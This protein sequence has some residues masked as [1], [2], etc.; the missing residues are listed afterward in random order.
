MKKGFLT[1]FL[2]MGLIALSA[3]SGFACDY[4]LL[5]QGISPLDTIK[6]AGVRVNQRYT[7]MD[8]VYRGTEELDNPG[9]K[10][11]YWTTEVTGFFSVNEDLTILGVL[12]YKKN[13]MDG[14]LNVLSDGT[15]E[16][17]SDMQGDSSGLGDISFIGRYSFFRRHTIDATTT[18]A[19]LVGIKLPTGRNDAKTNDGMEY[20]DSHM[21]PGTGSTDFIA[22][23]AF[24][25]AVQRVSVS[26]NLLGVIPTEG[27]SGDRHHRFGNALNYDLTAKY[28]VYPGPAGSMGPQLFLALGVNGE[29]RGREKDNGV[30]IA[31]SGGNTA[32][33][34]PGIQVVVAPHLVFEFT[35]QK[36]VYHNLYGTQMGEDYKAAGGV[37]YLF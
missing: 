13:G 20:L 25:H 35:Y 16:A 36:A 24:S 18:V 17:H 3:N 8:R 6:G 11:E 37:T 30:T 28:R 15:L 14:E 4:C 34:S 7:L 27:K 21:Q 26:A 31:D 19:A 10:E 23:L 32:Y 22:G 2:L 5:S 9:V 29:L 1:F 33:L 12:P